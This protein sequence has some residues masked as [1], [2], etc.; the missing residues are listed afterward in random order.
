MITTYSQ[1]FI[2]HLQLCLLIF[3]ENSEYY[4]WLANEQLQERILSVR[5][6]KNKINTLSNIKT[7]SENVSFVHQ[8]TISMIK[9][10]KIVIRKGT[11]DVNMHSHSV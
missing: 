2:N 9:K 8:A 5:N 4:S 1:L 10:R 6:G 7:N 11:V 3:F